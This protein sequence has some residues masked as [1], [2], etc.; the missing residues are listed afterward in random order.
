MTVDDAYTVR[1]VQ[2]VSLSV[3][4]TECHVA[5]DWPMRR[6]IGLTM[7]P[8]WRK[9]IEGAIGG[10]WGCTH[11]RELVFNSATA[12]FQAIPSYRST[13]GGTLPVP[14]PGAGSDKPPFYM[15]Q[16]M[17]WSFEGP[18]I[19]RLAPRFTAHRE[20]I[21]KRHDAGQKLGRDRPRG[22]NL[23]APSTRAIVGGVTNRRETI[24]FFRVEWPCH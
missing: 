5:A 23:V 11:L 24:V 13:N 18:V 20:P 21:R 12:A 22:S 16:C 9:S 6:L 17:S 1:D 2:T 19:K 15:N 3:P 7:G 10:V 14:E 8:G 4:F